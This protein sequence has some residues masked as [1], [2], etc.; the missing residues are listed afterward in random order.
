MDECFQ[1]PVLKNTIKQLY[2]FSSHN[3][4]IEHLHEHMLI[5]GPCLQEH[6]I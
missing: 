4:V 1:F 3:Y 6:F 5:H 2:T